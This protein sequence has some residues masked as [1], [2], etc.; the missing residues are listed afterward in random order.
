MT[1]IQES[2]NESNKPILY[3]D[4]FEYHPTIIRGLMIQKLNLGY[5]EELL[6]GIDPGQRLGLSV[7]YKGREIENSVY[8]SVDNLISH[9]IQILRELDAS[10][11]IVK[12]GNGSMSI[13]NHIATMLSM[14]FYYFDLKFVDECRTSPRFKNFNQRG[15]RDMRSAKYIAQRE[16]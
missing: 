1:T 12:I 10:H 2:P 4:V 13:A 16:S 7:F 9:I 14:R 6:I 11:K 5:D 8:T 15:K 3:E